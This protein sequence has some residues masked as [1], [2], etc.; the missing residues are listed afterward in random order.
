MAIDVNL[1]KELQTSQLKRFKT[2][3]EIYADAKRNTV[4]MRRSDIERAFEV[5]SASELIGWPS[6]LDRIAFLTLA[7]DVV[8]DYFGGSYINQLRE[9]IR[10]DFTIPRQCTHWIDYV[11]LGL[12]LGFIAGSNETLQSISNWVAFDMKVDPGIDSVSPAINVLYEHIACLLRGEQLPHNFSERFDAGVENKNEAFLGHMLLATADGD[13]SR[14]TE[15]L[16]L[17]VKNWAVKRKNARTIDIVSV[18]CSNLCGLWQT[19]VG[20]LPTYTAE[21]DFIQVR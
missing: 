20:P 5:V 21:V 18:D 7:C 9:D 10:E 3:D 19:V 2:V 14:F 15:S 11:Q 8:S 17:F 12:F 1:V 13:K 6:E 4:S 16:E